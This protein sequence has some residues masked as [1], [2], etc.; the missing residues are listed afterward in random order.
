MTCRH[1][2][3]ILGDQLDRDS[4]VLAEIDPARDIVLM[5]E[6]REESRRVWS[7][8][9][10]SALFLAAMRHHADWLRA[11]RYRVDYIDIHQPEAD[12]FASALQARLG[13]HRPDRL[14]MVE[15][16]EHGV[17]STIAMLC[18]RAA[19]AE[20]RSGRRTLLLEHFYRWMRRRH[21][22]LIDDGQPV[23][24]QWNFD[25]KNRRAFGRQGPGLLPAPL[26][27]EPDEITRQVLTDVAACLPDNPG[28]LDGFAWP[29]DR[30]QALAALEDF[31][32]HRLPAFGP[33]QDAMWQDE[34]WLYHSA[35]AAALNLKLLHPTEV[36]DAALAAYD[37]GEVPL[38]SVEGFIRQILGWREYV[39][40]IY[41]TEGPDYLQRNA[42]AA[43]RP[44]PAFYW[45][46]ETDMRCLAQVIGQ[47]LAT[48]YAHHIQRLMVTGLFAL[49]LGVRPQDVHAWYL[50][51]YVDAVE[52]VEAPNTLGMS[53]HADGGLLG[54]KP[55]VASGRYIERM[56][57]YC[58]GC[59]YAP[60]EATGDRACPFTTLY[61]DFL[62]RHR[63]RFG[64]HPRTAMQWRML[65]RLDDERRTTI[66]ARAETLR[67]Q[68][69]AT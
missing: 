16:G 12:S 69:A 67:G 58:Q 51:V 49:L 5:I 57:N 27:H 45:T 29:V 35:L 65:E 25:A 4:A 61:W 55:Y 39:H 10:R 26:Q 8:K 68:F 46:G 30:E 40:G 19:F 7:H 53:Q 15:A 20:W 18:S 63:Q 11:Q 52:W 66:A 64:R 50:A 2:I 56:S 9:A 38:A 28:S 33:Y 34:P 13:R 42:L 31:I 60:G 47:T 17:E 1:L 36:I 59:R 44:L 3:L 37:S 54:S 22:I 6:A 32:R 43:D 41:W 14:R 23:G 21:R 48:G 62:I 24:G